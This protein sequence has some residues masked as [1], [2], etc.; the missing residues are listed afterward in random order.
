AAVLLSP[1][2]CGSLKWTARKPPLPERALALV[3]RTVDTGRVWD[4]QA[5]ARWLHEEEE[6]HKR[7]LVAGKGNAGVIAAYPTLLESCIEEL[8]LVEPPASH[9]DGPTFLNVLRVLDV[10]D[11]L[12]LLAPRRLTVVHGPSTG[13]EQVRRI[14]RAAGA[15]EKFSA[16]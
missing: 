15:E 16:Q 13:V 4:V 14:F 3:G 11:A 5:A 2:G 12:G 6:P 9:K 10:P 1:R 8:S 7:L